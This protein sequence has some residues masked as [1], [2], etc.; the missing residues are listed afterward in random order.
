MPKF[1]FHVYDQVVSLDEQGVE[2][3]NASLARDAAIR[4]ARELAAEE[5]VRDGKVY[6]HHRIEVE[7]AQ[8]RPVLTL[9]F[10]AAFRVVGP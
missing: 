9:P 8:G 2:L 1:Y 5:I 6:L 3:K 10:S 4:A 7:D